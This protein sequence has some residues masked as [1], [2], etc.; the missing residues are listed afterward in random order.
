MQ[1]PLQSVLPDGHVHA[2]LV[3]LVP[4]VQTFPHAPQ[5]ASSLVVSMQ[6]L[7]HC[8]SPEP[9]CEAHLPAEHTWVD[10]Q[11]LPHAPQFFAS[12]A[13]SVQALPHAMPFAQT[14]APSLHDAPLGQTVP[15]A[16]QFFASDPRSTHAWLQLVSPGVQS[17]LHTPCEQTWLLLQTELQPPQCCGSEVGSTH[18]D[19]QAI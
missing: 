15:H 2:L 9:H 5:F 11:T 18:T 7:P 8:V 13:V 1:V 10:P 3:Q 16:P 17:P 12:E 4:P 14:H 6:E 19:P